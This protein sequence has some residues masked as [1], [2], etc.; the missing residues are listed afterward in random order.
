MNWPEEGRKFRFTNTTLLLEKAELS[1]WGQ[2]AQIEIGDLDISNALYFI[3]HLWILKHLQLLYVSCHCRPFWFYHFVPGDQCTMK[4]VTRREPL[5]VKIRHL[6]SVLESNWWVWI[7]AYFTQI[8][9]CLYLARKFTSKT[10]DICRR[11]LFLCCY[12]SLPMSRK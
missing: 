7:W 9:D 10:F 4:R 12:S 11:F 1:N 5:R 2:S 3:M 8:L 6:M